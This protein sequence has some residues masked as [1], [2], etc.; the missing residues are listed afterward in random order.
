MNVIEV[1]GSLRTVL[2][3]KEAKSLRKEEK[4]PCVI[5]GGEAPV[6]I[7][8]AQAELRKLIF[9]PNIY[10]V[11]LK[12]DGKEYKSIM[13][14]VQFDPVS[15]AVTHIDF[16]QISEDKAVKIEVPVKVKGFSKG[17]KAGGKLKQDLRKLRIK[18]LPA[19]LPDFVEINV[20][21]LE[22]G[23]AI[24]VGE[25]IRENIEFLNNKSTPVVSVVITRAAKAA[26]VA[27][28]AAEAKTTKKK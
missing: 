24:K 10:I 8:V 17:V 14:D 12:I 23:Q 16:L 4:V 1:N 19:F 13:Q 21:N 22:I 18:A 2:G 25:L 26:L 28:A 5:Y 20:E 27:A 9:T 3:K 11:N 15:D 7:S 6:H